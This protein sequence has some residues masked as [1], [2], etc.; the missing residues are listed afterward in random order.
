VGPIPRYK[1]IVSYRVLL[2]PLYVPL[3]FG[4]IRPLL[5]EMQARSAPSLRRIHALRYKVASVL[6][7]AC[8]FV[9]APFAVLEIRSYALDLSADR[10]KATAVA[11]N[12]AKYNDEVAQANHEI[13]VK[14]LAAYSEPI[15]PVQESVLT[16]YIAS[17]AS[18]LLAEQI[19]SASQH[20]CCGVLVLS[21]LAGSRNA[22]SEAL[23]N[24][25]DHALQLPDNPASSP[26][27][28]K[29]GVLESLAANPNTPSPILHAL[30]SDSPRARTKAPDNPN[31]PPSEKINYL[32]KASDSSDVGER[33]AAARNAAT[34]PGV[35]EKLSS[36]SDAIVLTVADSLS[37]PTTFLEQIL[38]TSKNE[39]VRSTAKHNL[40]FRRSH[41]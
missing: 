41:R 11:G 26:Y 27:G 19:T 2:L 22:P 33:L 24:I 14:G 29:A 1:P 10:A 25:Y 23:Q 9:S 31:T 15:T 6:F 35:L 18:T 7:I 16:N 37:T 28:G 12:R 5:A 4:L 21:C 34:P 13:L 20:Y 8:L 39:A 38:A 17:H 3:A 30:Q 40:D 32:R 36:D